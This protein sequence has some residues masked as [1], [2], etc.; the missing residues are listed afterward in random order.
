MIQGQWSEIV[1][2]KFPDRF[3][4]IDLDAFNIMPN[5][6]YG[7]IIWVGAPLV[8]AHPGNGIHG[9]T[10]PMGA[11]VDRATVYRATTRVAPTLG[12]VVGAIKSL[13]TV[14][15]TCGVKQC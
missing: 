11:T 9:A 1:W 12:D 4:Y 7:I 15:Y 3:P 2:N 5:H 8:G 14:E 13:V 6:I 10:E